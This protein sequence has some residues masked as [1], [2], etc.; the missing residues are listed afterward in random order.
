M[1]Y[2]VY[3]Y[4]YATTVEAAKNEAKH[5][6]RLLKGHKPDYPVFFDMEEDRITKLGKTKI[7]EITKA[8]CKCIEDAGFV[9]GTYANTN[10]Y[11]N[12]LTD[13]WYDTKV[14]WLAQYYNKVTYKG[15]YDIW[16]Y[17]DKGSVAGINANVDMNFCYLSFLE[18]DVDNDGKVTAA[19]ARKILRLPLD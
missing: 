6:L 12:Y 3:L 10:W 5:V 18:G 17:S 7:L 9:Y 15:H 8:F 4:S 11:N 19:D 13:K 16:Q 2:G 1:P 14:K